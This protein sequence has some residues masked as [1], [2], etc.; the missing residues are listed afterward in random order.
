VGGWEVTAAKDIAN[1]GEKNKSDIKNKNKK[2]PYA[3][4]RTF[5]QTVPSP[6]RKWVVLRPFQEERG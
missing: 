1:S 3:K 4:K 6:I 5:M 2:R